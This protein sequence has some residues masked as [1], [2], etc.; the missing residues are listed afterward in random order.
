MAGAGGVLRLP[1]LGRMPCDRVELGLPEIADVLFQLAAKQHIIFSLSSRPV[2]DE[3]FS[4]GQDFMSF[5]GE[6]EV[7]ASAV[8]GRFLCQETQ[9]LKPPQYFAHALP[10]DTKCCG[11]I[12]DCGGF[13]GC[14][15]L[16]RIQCGCGKS[17]F[18]QAAVEA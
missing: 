11:E 5:R 15:C 7:R 14:C 8:A 18:G 16:Q 12:G 6:A 2:T 3:V 4:G 9:A 13:E 1:V 10:A 17:E